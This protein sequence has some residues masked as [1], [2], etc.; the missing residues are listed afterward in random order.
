MFAANVSNPQ[1][2]VRS[3]GVALAI[4]A[5]LALL[6]SGCGGSA[7]SAGSSAKLTIANFDPFSGPNA[8]Y[9]YV[10][11]A[12]CMAAIHLINADGGA[13]GH[14]LTCQIVDSRGDPADAVPA[15]QK[16]LTTTN[17]L[18][19]IVDQDSGVL[20]ATVPLFDQAHIPDISIGGDVP[21]DHN[22]YQYF[23]RTVAGDDQAG[24]ALA[25]YIFF[26]TPYRRVAAMFGTDAAAQ[27]NIP[28]LVNGAKHLG[29]QIVL[30][31]PI[32]IDQQTYATEVQKLKNSNA[33]VFTSEFDPQTAG[34]ILGQLKQSGVTMPGILTSGTFVPTWDTAAKS[35]VGASTF[36]SQYIRVMPYAYASG[37]AYNTWIQGLKAIES[38]VRGAN[39]DAGQFYS[40]APYDNV[41]ELA[42]AIQA[43]HSTNPTVI[44]QWIPKVSSGSTIVHTFAEGKAALEQGKTINYVGVIGQ[45]HFDKYHN[46][47]GIWAA[48]KPLSNKVATL[49]SAKELQQ[50]IG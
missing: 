21:F 12:G 3:A 13:N 37:P 11:Q 4:A 42:L 34:V 26:K 2:R 7:A 46:S 23:W 40:Q 50:A 43:S 8:D 9:G 28:G 47:P 48:Q 31:E 45:I 20:S 27:G 38:Q 5:G 41:N 32:A 16:M 35:A 36:T 39:Q 49:L 19:G 10:E 1:R 44:N 17:N 33:Q 22:H 6:I 14:K 29:L 24:D 25:A 15:A 18:V 30:N